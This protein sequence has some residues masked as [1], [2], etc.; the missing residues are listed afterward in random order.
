MTLGRIPTRLMAKAKEAISTTYMGIVPAAVASTVMEPGPITIPCYGRFLKMSQ[1]RNTDNGTPK[2]IGVE[3]YTFTLRIE[4]YWRP[5]S[6]L[7][8]TRWVDQASQAYCCSQCFAARLRLPAGL[9]RVPL[10]PAFFQSQLLR[11][12]RRADLI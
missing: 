1:T 4:E 9:S 5:M 7:R 12:R 3:S 2:L 6:V 8:M 11:K 10:P